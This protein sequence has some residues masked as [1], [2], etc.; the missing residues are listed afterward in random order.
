MAHAIA[1][2]LVQNGHFYG[3][4]LATFFGV[5]QVAEYFNPKPQILPACSTEQ[6]YATAGEMAASVAQAP[7]ATVFRATT[8]TESHDT[9]TSIITVSSV[10]TITVPLSVK[11]ETSTYTA[12][13]IQTSTITATET[14]M[15][16]ETVI[17]DAA[18]QPSD[19][20]S[21]LKWGLIAVAAV[22]NFVYSFHL[23]RITRQKWYIN[24]VEETNKME[25]E[26]NEAVQER[27]KLKQKVARLEDTAKQNLAAKQTE[28]SNLQT[29]IRKQ[30]TRWE[31]FAETVEQ[32]DGIKL[33]EDWFDQE[34]WLETVVE[35]F[36]KHREGI[37]YQ[38]HWDKAHELDKKLTE[39]KE[40][41]DDLRRKEESLI[42]TIHEC[43]KN[44]EGGLMDRMYDAWTKLAER[45]VEVI[46]MKEQV[47]TKD[48]FTG[49]VN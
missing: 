14:S 18:S 29:T 11:A 21:W 25:R 3:L 27:Q 45:E 44:V 7:P 6:L 8:V 36:Q 47:R 34:D 26:R 38:K 23:Y 2:H 16:T 49:F 46:K 42:H 32:L 20:Y 40:E 35:T 1:L 15:A 28:R 10:S 22:C 4:G 33:E 48:G 12:T 17:I 31:R 41:I 5:P 19:L 9:A 30:N 37:S 39:A 43:G 24:V 13:S